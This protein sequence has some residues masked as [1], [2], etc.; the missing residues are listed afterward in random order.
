MNGVVLVRVRRRSVFLTTYLINLALNFEWSVPAW[1]LLVLHFKLGL[2]WWPFWT[3]LALWLVVILVRSVFVY[4]VY[5]QPSNPSP[6]K[7]NVN[8]YSQKGYRTLKEQREND[9]NNR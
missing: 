1:I 8:P 9:G 4:W 7:K 6:P 3:A 5:S 2:P